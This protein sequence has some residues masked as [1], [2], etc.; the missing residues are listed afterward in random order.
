MVLPRLTWDPDLS[1]EVVESVKK[2]RGLGVCQTPDWVGCFSA[3]SK[4][5]NLKYCPVVVTFVQ[6][7]R[8]E[9]PKTSRSRPSVDVTVTVLQFFLGHN[10]VEVFKNKH[11]QHCLLRELASILHFLMQPTIVSSYNHTAESIEVQPYSVRKYVL[12]CIRVHRS[13][14]WQ[15]S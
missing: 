13:A 1:H 11:T 12:L 5:R 3:S 4:I 2:A 14:R 9:D 7:S 10:I 6:R 8:H 15:I